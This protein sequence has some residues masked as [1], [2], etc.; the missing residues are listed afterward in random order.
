MAI[1][2][3]SSGWNQGGLGRGWGRMVRK[4]HEQA[5]EVVGPL[6]RSEFVQ[7]GEMSISLQNSG[8]DDLV[9]VAQQKLERWVWHPGGF[10]LIS[11]WSPRGQGMSS[12]LPCMI[13]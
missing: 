12:P 2:L 1:L 3:G 7:W 4:L 10:V 8:T 6:H 5:L 13:P 11:G 9:S